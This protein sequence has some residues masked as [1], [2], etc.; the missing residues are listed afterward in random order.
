MAHDSF[1]NTSVAMRQQMGVDA[2]N[3]GPLTD[4]MRL[5]TG[6]VLVDEL[7][8]PRVEPETLVIVDAVGEPTRA[9]AALEVVDSVYTD[10]RLTL[11]DNTADWSSAGRFVV[12][13][14]LD[15]LIDR[16]SSV[17]VDLIVDGVRV[18]RQREPL[19]TATV[20]RC[21]WLGV[22]LAKRGLALR[23]RRCGPQRWPHPSVRPRCR[24]DHL[25]RVRRSMRGASVEEGASHGIG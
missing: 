1:A 19:P 2:P 22:Q 7:T 11:A 5:D 13:S 9:Y 18:A 14:L 24:V 20:L 6:A 15:V 25:G 16:L 21:R 23:P 8:Q 12:G 17:D 3:Y 4:V 10:H